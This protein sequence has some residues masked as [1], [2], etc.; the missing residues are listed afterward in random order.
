MLQACSQADPVLAPTHLLTAQS[1]GEVFRIRMFEPS[2][3][4]KAGRLVLT[5]PGWGERS[6]GNDRLHAALLEAGFRVAALD[7]PQWAADNAGA[8]IPSKVTR[9]VDFSLASDGDEAASQAAGD[10][11]VRRG[12]QRMAAALAA[13]EEHGPAAAV[14]FSLG[15]SWAAEAA[16][17]APS[18]AA[19]VNLDGW[20][21]GQ[22]LKQPLACAYLWVR[23]KPFT[24]AAS[25]EG[26]RVA[27]WIARDLAAHE[28]FGHRADVAWAT[29]VQSPHGQLSRGAGA[30]AKAHRQAIV[31][32]LKAW[33]RGDQALGAAITFGGD[34]RQDRVTGAPSDT[35]QTDPNS[36]SLGETSKN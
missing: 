2:V 27:R 30:R 16:L 14:G 4:A 34:L 28:R 26:R 36:S 25:A 12:A 17:T 21:F 7:A 5:A 3:G 24:P 23:S 31:D 32:F 1:E 13:L 18:I 15:G 20:L 10:E 29:A 6:E 9:P 19:V 33:A 22:A 8:V 35:T 11:R